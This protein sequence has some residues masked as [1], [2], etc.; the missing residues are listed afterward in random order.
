MDF[1]G[2]SVIKNPPVKQ[3]TQRWSIDPKDPLK[4]EM[5]V[6]PVG[7]LAWEIPWAEEAGGLTVHG[8]AERAGH[9]LATRQQQQSVS[10]FFGGYL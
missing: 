1:P 7:I 8:V 10:W 3:E 2:R 6:Y 4:K 5:S 9:D